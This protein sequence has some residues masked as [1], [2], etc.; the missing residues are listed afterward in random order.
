MGI[1]K[2]Y[3]LNNTLLFTSCIPNCGFISIFKDKTT[4]FM[5]RKTMNNC[6]KKFLS[7][8]LLKFVHKNGS[9]YW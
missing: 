2:K 4:F 8:N 9:N 5:S 1:K 6:K 3:H 7:L